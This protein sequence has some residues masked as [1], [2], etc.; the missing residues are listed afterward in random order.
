[1]SADPSEVGL[2]VERVLCGDHQAYNALADLFYSPIY[3]HARNIVHDADEAHDISQEAFLQAYLQLDTLQDRTKFS[4]WLR[5]IATHL[6][7]NWNTRYRWRQRSLETWL[8]GNGES[9]D[10]RVDRFDAL[11]ESRTPESR[12]IHAE[13]RW[14]VADALLSLPKVDRDLFRQFYFQELSYREIGDHLGVSPQVV[15]GR[16]QA[17][18]NRLKS[19]VAQMADELLDAAFGN[20]P[21]PT[22]LHSRRSARNAQPIDVN[23]DV[24]HILSYG[25]P[26]ILK[27]GSGYK[28][29]IGH[30]PGRAETSSLPHQII[31]LTSP[32]G[33]HW[34]NR[35]PVFELYAGPASDRFDRYGI[36]GFCVL[37]D[38]SAYR[39]WYTGYMN[40][41]A[42]ASKIGYAISRDGLDWE[43]ISGL[44]SGGAVV[45]RGAAEAYD[46]DGAGS[47]FVLYER[48]VYKMWYGAIPA[49]RDEHG[50][51]RAI[52]IA[53]AES[54]DG[55]VWEKQGKVLSPDPR[56]SFDQ[57]WIYPGSVVKKGNVY[58]MWYTVDDDLQ[59]IYAI[60]YATSPDGKRWT[61]QG[62]VMGGESAFDQATNPSVVWDEEECRMWCQ[63]LEGIV[64]T[65]LDKN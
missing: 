38:G 16:L 17:A 20:R 45:D 2:L 8:E 23:T 59:R 21:R 24:Q 36:G 14:L 54:T 4:P 60:G 53:Y 48:G 3:A 33:L 15:Q 5:S 40:E 34:T 35:G 41:P 18:R 51:F 28:A 43:P 61:K 12:Y 13:E 55:I 63:T 31:H 46:G 57:R 26:R 29:W 50:T 44:E 49:E 47:P 30:I 25:I 37:Y 65:G 19:K 42:G 56:G 6:A 9:P 22:H 7:Q 11:V 62:K 64:C 10:R 39:M 27:I 58:H 32:D 1:M 52:H